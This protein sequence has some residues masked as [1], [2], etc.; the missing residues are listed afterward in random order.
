MLIRLHIIWKNNLYKFKGFLLKLYLLIHGCKVGK[1]LRV[2]Q[3]PH[4]RAVPN[5]NIILGDH[6]SIGTNIVFQPLGK[7]RIILED[8]VKLIHDVFISAAEEVCIGNHTGIAERCSIRDTEHSITVGKPMYMQPL[9]SHPIRIGSDVQLSVGCTV[10]AGSRIAD[11]ALIGVGCIVTRNLRT[12][13]NGIYLGNPPK[14]I[15]KRPP[16]LI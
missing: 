3:F 5:H 6:V 14:L 13:E 11:G 2:V 15:G 4:F 1:G 12:V 16:T 8:H 10:L 9:V 7:G